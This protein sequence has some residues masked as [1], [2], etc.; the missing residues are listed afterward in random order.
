MVLTRYPCSYLAYSF[1]KSFDS[2]DESY[3][4][5]FLHC[6]FRICHMLIHILLHKVGNHIDVQSGEWTARDAGIGAGVDSLFEYLVKGAYLLRQS[7]WIKVI[8]S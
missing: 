2:V 3:L 5:S 7:E 8:I 6:Q 4:S 1:S